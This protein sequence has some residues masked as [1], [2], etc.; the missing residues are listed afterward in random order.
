MFAGR[1][2]RGVE[3]ERLRG[4]G[5]DHRDPLESAC[6]IGVVPP[7]RVEVTVAH[8]ARSR[9]HARLA[10]TDEPVV[11]GLDADRR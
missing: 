6:V 5:E 1:D 11:I 8:D 7:R 3:R 10:R 2:A 4:A 9:C